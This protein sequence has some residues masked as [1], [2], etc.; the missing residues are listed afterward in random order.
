MKT[1]LSY[2]AP[3]TIVHKFVTFKHCHLTVPLV[4]VIW[5]VWIDNNINL[6]KQ[7]SVVVKSCFFHLLLLAKV[8]QFLSCKHF[9][10]AMHAFITSRLDYCNSLYI[11]VSQKNITHLQLVQN[12]AACLLKGKC[13]FEHITPVLISLHWLPIKFR[14]D[15]KVLL[16]V[17][18]SLQNLAPQY[19]SELLHPKLKSI[20][21]RSGESNLLS[22]P[23][24]RLK[25]RGDRA[26]TAYGPK[27]WNSLPSNIRS[28]QIL[29]FFKTSL[30]THPF[31]LAFNVT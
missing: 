17:F 29:T 16:F 31:S 13:K 8:K 27:L 26:F 30:K 4:F 7:I 12:A 19:L 11:G 22:V 15:F 1:R 25:N 28:A 9:E 5:G 23:R 3:V 24:T 2:L 6:E 10:I 20:L 21:L 14:I 18:K